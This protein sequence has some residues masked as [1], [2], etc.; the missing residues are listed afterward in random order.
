MTARRASRS[1]Q[2]ERRLRRENDGAGLPIKPRSGP[3]EEGG[4]SLGLKARSAN[5]LAARFSRAGAEGGARLSPCAG[6]AGRAGTAPPGG[7]VPARSARGASLGPR[8]MCPGPPCGQAPAGPSSA[9]IPPHG[10]AQ[11][12]TCAL[13]SPRPRQ[14]PALPV[15][16]GPGDSPGTERARDRGRALRRGSRGSAVPSV[17]PQLRSV[18]EPK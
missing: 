2:G 1:A 13:A 11:A 10:G 8:L 3:W 4:V 5:R 7:A 6:H 15:Q 12:Q 17:Y 14:L 18:P 16:P 9:G